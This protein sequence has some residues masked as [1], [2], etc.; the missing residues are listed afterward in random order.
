MSVDRYV[1]GIL[2]VE[3]TSLPDT[4]NTHCNISKGHLMDVEE[5]HSFDVKNGAAWIH[6]GVQKIFCTNVYDG[7]IFEQ[8]VSCNRRH[9]VMHLEG[10]HRIPV[11]D[12]DPLTFTSRMADPEL[13]PP[14][15]TGSQKQTPMGWALPDAAPAQ[16]GVI[17]LVDEVDEG[18]HDDD[19]EEPGTLV[20][21]SHVTDEQF[22]DAFGT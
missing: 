19:E 3:T 15:Y 6:A 22:E 2:K 5:G 17:D 10:N 20:R 4:E 21:T 1:E 11:A 14:I 12:R 7:K 9:Y 13:T 8:D 18:K 16:D